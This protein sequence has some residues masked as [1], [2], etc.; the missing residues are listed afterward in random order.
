MMGLR[1]VE[2]LGVCLFAVSLGCCM[3]ALANYLIDDSFGYW[4]DDNENENSEDDE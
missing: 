3:I 2:F 4:G 1:V